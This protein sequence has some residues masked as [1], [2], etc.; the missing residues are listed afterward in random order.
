MTP[1]GSGLGTYG[2]A[3]NRALKGIVNRACAIDPDGPESLFGIIADAT[4]PGSSAEG[5]A[6]TAVLYNTDSSSGSFSPDRVCTFGV[7]T[8]TAGRS[9][10]TGTATINGSA[11]AALSRDVYVTRATR[12]GLGSGSPDFSVIF[13]EFAATGNAVQSN[14]VKIADK[15]TSKAKYRY[16]IASYKLVARSTRTPFTVSAQATPA[17]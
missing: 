8:T 4:D 13:P 14:Q 2:S 16:A 3:A 9:V 10:L 6:V 12:T 5:L 11:S 15:N 7:L 1:S 17:P